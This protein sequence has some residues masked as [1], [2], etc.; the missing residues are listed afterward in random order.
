M[1]GAAKLSIKQINL[2][3]SN[4]DSRTSKNN[5]SLKIIKPK[6]FRNFPLVAGSN[7]GLSFVCQ[8]YG[9]LEVSQK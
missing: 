6:I 1:V 8:A 5:L 4:V 2:S 7:I 3:V 9:T